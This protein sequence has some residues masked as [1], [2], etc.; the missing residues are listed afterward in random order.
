[1]IGA[2]FFA[3]VE[4]PKSIL[5]Q[6]SGLISAVS[7]FSW[8]AIAIVFLVLMRARLGELIAIGMN[9]L[10]HAADIELG[11]LKLKGA[12]ISVSGEVIK[13]DS[14]YAEV[15]QAKKADLEERHEIYEK[16]RKLMLVHTIKPA[17]PKETI[18]GVRVFDVSVF[19]V[20][21]RGFGKLNDIKTV[22][23]YFGDKWGAG[24]YGSKYVISNS[25]SSFALTAQMYGACICVAEIE[26]HTGELIK[27]H[28]YLDVE[29]A[30]VYGIPLR[31]ARK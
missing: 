22:S 28:R 9:R 20:S 12:L 16:Q 14:D 25:N 19:V 8:P 17:E 18:E 6:I 10:E 7:G 13:D 15:V 11:S 31:E 26:F 23:Y 29:M 30:P 1:M 3:A 4:A 2:V 24:T 21:H 5:D 27:E